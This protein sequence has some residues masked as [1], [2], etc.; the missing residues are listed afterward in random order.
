MGW[1]EQKKSLEFEGILPQRS[2][3]PQITET[4]AIL[5]TQ[6]DDM[7]AQAIAYTM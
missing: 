2:K 6:V 3:S 4:I 1:E 7:T 5:E